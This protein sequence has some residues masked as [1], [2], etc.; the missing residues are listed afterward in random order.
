MK[1]DIKEIIKDFLNKGLPQKIETSN[2]EDPDI[3]N[4]FSLQHELGIYLREHLGENYKVQF[5]RNAKKLWGKFKNEDWQKTEMDIFVY[6]KNEKK[7]IQDIDE[8]YAIELK[9]PKNGQYP[10][11]MYSFIKDIKFMQQVKEKKHFARTFVLTLVDNPNFYR[12]TDKK[13]KGEK[14]NEIYKYFR[15][16][17]KNISLSTKKIEA[18]EILPKTIKK[19]T[20][21][22]KKIEEFQNEESQ[23]V[24]SITLNQQIT[25]KIKWELISQ[26]LRYYFME[27]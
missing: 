19:P 23:K 25:K 8:I 10:E 6:K 4:E 24:K 5:E 14:E 13:K 18:E 12:K 21:Q 26:K 11:Q 2:N 17:D 3:Y 16:K 27:I 7:K 1:M 20:G 9:Y 22:D 15:C